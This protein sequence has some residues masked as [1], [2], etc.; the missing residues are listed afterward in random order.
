MFHLQVRMRRDIPYARLSE[1]HP[2]SVLHVWCNFD[3]DIVETK[4]PTADAAQALRQDIEESFAPSVRLIEM[5]AGNHLQAFAD[6]CSHD[7][8]TGVTRTIETRD[9][10]RYEPLTFEAGWQSFSFL[11][12]NEARV[13]EILDRLSE[14]G[15][16]EI[17]TKRKLRSP[18]VSQTVLLP[19]DSLLAGLTPRQASA[20]ESALSRGYY[21]VPRRSTAK[22]VA[23][24]VG[25]PRT[26]FEQSLRKAE[27][28]IMR[29]VAPYVRLLHG[30]QGLDGATSRRR[31]AAAD[32]SA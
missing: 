24:D 5:Q 29:S 27:S 18:L 32:R 12:V 17:L 14:K 10:I 1:R 2:D 20:F 11:C 22:D 31:E 19:V 3:R 4:S 13:S 8:D 25:T 30:P 9:G 28:K 7:Y 15:D 16:L 6:A 26:T 21:E 23:K